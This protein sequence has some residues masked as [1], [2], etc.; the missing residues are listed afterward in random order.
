MPRL[1]RLPPCKLPREGLQFRSRIRKEQG[2]RKTGRKGLYGTRERLVPTSACFLVMG[3]PSEHARN[4]WSMKGRGRTSEG[5]PD[6]DQVKH[7]PLAVLTLTPSAASP[8]AAPHPRSKSNSVPPNDFT[9]IITTTSS[10]IF[11]G[12]RRNESASD[13]QTWTWSA[14]ATK[15]DSRYQSIDLTLVPLLTPLA[16]ER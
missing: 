13:R 1:D 11:G 12:K 4:A 15:D 10:S 8:R 7:V 16:S 2:V 3:S 6:N 9:A 5:S 14:E